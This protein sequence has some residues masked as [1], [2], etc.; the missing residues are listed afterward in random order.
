M[1]LLVETGL[2]PIARLSE[3]MRETDEIFAM[4]AALINL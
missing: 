2:I 3:L 1:E 4:T